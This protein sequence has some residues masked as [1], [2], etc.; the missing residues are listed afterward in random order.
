MAT[1]DC[2]AVGEYVVLPLEKATWAEVQEVQYLFTVSPNLELAGS[3]VQ[4]FRNLLFWSNPKAYSGDHA[5]PDRRDA[6]PE[7]LADVRRALAGSVPDV[8]A[9]AWKHLPTFNPRNDCRALVITYGLKANLEKPV[10]WPELAVEAR[11]REVARL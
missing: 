5:L 7:L 4:P 2:P 11:E 1:G 10:Q 6:G 8:R 3:P 9:V